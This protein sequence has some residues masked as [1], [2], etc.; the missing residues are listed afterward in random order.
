MKTQAEYLA[1]RRERVRVMH[2]E[3]KTTGEML[4]ELGGVVNRREIYRH[5]AALGLTG[6]ECRK[7]RPKW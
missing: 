3:G 4:K 7:V 2:G 5:Y 6:H 1:E